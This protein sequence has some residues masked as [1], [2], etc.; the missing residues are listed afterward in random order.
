MSQT[1]ERVITF[2]EQEIVLP[3]GVTSA[4][5]ALE[6]LVWQN[7][8]IKAFL[9][10][11]RVLDEVL[12]SNYAILN[13]SPERLLEIWN[14][15]REVS[16]LMREQLEPLLQGASKMPD[17]ERA[18][19]RAVVALDLLT[20]SVLNDVDRFPEDVMSDQ[21]LELRKTL[22]ISIGKLHAFLQ[23]TFGELMSADPRS[24]HDADYYIS[25]RFPRDIEEAEWL[26]KTIERLQ[27]YL[28]KTSQP[29]RETLI[30]LIG[31]MRRHLTVPS[32]AA[33]EDAKGFLGILSDALTPKL[34]EIL[35][36]RGV[37]F[38][39]MEILDRYMKSIP[40]GCQVVIALQVAGRKAIEATKNVT[41]ESM[42]ER[43]QAVRDLLTIHRTLATEMALYLEELDRTLQDLVAFTPL[44]LD[45]LRKRRALLSALSET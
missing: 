42:M 37:R 12:E 33:W 11:F 24:H 30:P 2:A 16:E 7:P 36:M 17:L 27:R 32:G 26:Y 5:W 1:G 13:C 43:E 10:C 18:R 34:R 9:G 23:D 38:Y 4:D 8:R 35:A 21:L 15:V 19:T 29:R 25:K 20:R 31:R 22:C 6:R 40:A 3:D 39:E 28:A 44:W 45:S 14:K 41:G